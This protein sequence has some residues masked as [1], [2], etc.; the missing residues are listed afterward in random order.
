MNKKIR[1][2]CL[3]L[4][5]TATSCKQVTESKPIRFD[6]LNEKPIE[7]ID[8]VKYEG[9]IIG[10]DFNRDEVYIQT[11][12]AGKGKYAISIVDIPS[13][14][15]KREMQLKTGG[16]ESPTGFYNP[17]HMQ[18]LDGNYII[19]DQ[20]HKILVF[21]EQLNHLYTNMFYQLRYFLDF[22]MYENQ[23]F[24]VI[25]AKKNMFKF[26]R[27]NIRIYRLRKNSRPVHKKD[28]H[29]FSNKSLQPQDLQNQ[30]F[31][32][33]GEFWPSGK[34]FHKNGKIYYANYDEKQY[35]RYDIRENKSVSFDLDYL[36]PKK[37]SQE[38]ADRFLFYHSNGWQDRIFRRDGIRVVAVPYS[39]PLYQFG[40]FDVGANKIGIIGDL[41]IETEDLKFRLDVL[42]A[43]SGKYLESVR[44][45]F[46]DG[47]LQNI[48][49]GARG[50]QPTFINMD[51][52]YYLWNNAVG[53][54]VIDYVHI[55]TFKIKPDNTGTTGTK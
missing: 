49:D 26:Y 42:D 32:H 8:T 25:G 6:G 37:F 18:F 48:G 50:M 15:L 43:D 4:I 22:Y 40:I 31:M 13:K 34:G 29:V 36:K 19:V 45:P 28:L 10:A 5:I 27:N 55:T 46:G 39:E 47:I 44:F 52:G 14:K 1:I 23:K 16:F 21:D 51:K 33:K 17:S 9:F 41:D 3:M 54:D 53:E 38:T 30:K 11:V 20:F 35:F 2:I 7:F 12:S 24:F